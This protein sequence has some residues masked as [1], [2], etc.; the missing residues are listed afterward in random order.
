[1]KTTTVAPKLWKLALLAA[2]FLIPAVNQAQSTAC[3]VNA[4]KYTWDPVERCCNP[5]PR[6]DCYSICF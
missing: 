6:F 3:P 2:L 1:M 5:D 4:C